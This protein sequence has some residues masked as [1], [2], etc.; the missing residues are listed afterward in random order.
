[1]PTPEP[2]RPRPSRPVRSA[3]TGLAALLGLFLFWLLSG[4]NLEGNLPR[5]GSPEHRLDSALIQEL[6]RA[7]PERRVGGG[8]G[9][10]KKKKEKA[11]SNRRAQQA[12]EREAQSLINPLGVDGIPVGG[13]PVRPGDL[14][15]EIEAWLAEN[16]TGDIAKGTAATYQRGWEKWL[17]WANFSHLGH[18]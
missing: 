6:V 17:W 9:T 10:A 3:R 18:R 2:F 16:M 12:R 13:P 8:A 7:E 1:M 14:D 11:R 4:T 5:W 15:E